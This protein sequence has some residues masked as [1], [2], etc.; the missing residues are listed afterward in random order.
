MTK[1]TSHKRSV[2]SGTIALFAMCII[3]YGVIGIIIGLIVNIFV[4]EFRWYY[5]LLI[6]LAVA[7]IALL[8]STLS[9][10]SHVRS[11]IRGAKQQEDEYPQLKDT[12]KELAEK[13]KIKTPYVFVK[14]S[15]DPNAYACGLGRDTVIIVNDSLLELLN[16]D[17][18]KGVLAHEIIHIRNKETLTTVLTARVGNI[19]TLFSKYVGLVFLFGGI[20]ILVKCKKL[21]KEDQ[22]AAKKALSIIARVILTVI[23]ICLTA[24]GGV[25]SIF[26]PIARILKLS[27]SKDREFNADKEAVSLTDDPG[28]II[29]ALEKLDDVKISYKDID[30]RYCD[31][32]F[33]DHRH[34]NVINN[35]MKTHP[36]AKKR[37][38]R[39]KGEPDDETASD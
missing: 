9:V 36:S 4:P 17:E 25:L 12:V 3:V 29:N 22:S 35:I 23:G 19:T 32:M 10:H 27:I 2:N 15:K 28:S 8:Y 13:A 26:F 39:L 38:K 33:V 6:M 5:G 16:Q 21:N 20:M 18:L 24:I 14:K 31:L 34:A 30:D 37:I 1:D 7:V 11:A